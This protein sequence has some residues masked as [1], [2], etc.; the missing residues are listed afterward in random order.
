MKLILAAVLLGAGPLVASSA[1]GDGTA[2]PKSMAAVGTVRGSVVFS[3][4]PPKPKMIK[5]EKKKAAECEC[6]TK[7]IDRSLLV[8]PS[9]GIANVVVTV[10]VPGVTA[11]PSKQPLVM[12]NRACRYEPHVLVVPVGSTVE[13]K[14]SD[15]T[16]HNV[17]TLPRRN[18]GI[19]RTVSSGSSVK[20]VQK[21]AEAYAVVCDIHPW[22]KGW[23]FV[24]DTP[25]VALTDAQGAF[26]IS[27]LPP[28]KYQ[29]KLWHETLGRSTVEITITAGSVTTVQTSMSPKK[30][31]GRR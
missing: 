6:D 22:M 16:S 4:K 14:N 3:E 18:R 10:E 31:R 1:D 2:T 7:G 21:R 27:G 26:Q 11:Q 15:P 29:A 20:E 12:N 24:T 28:G 19:N 13:F 8:H 9:G 25:F 17:H 5:I 23:I 30:K